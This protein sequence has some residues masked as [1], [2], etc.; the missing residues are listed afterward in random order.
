MALETIVPGIPVSVVANLT[1]E[2]AVLLP[3]PSDSRRQGGYE[4]LSA[5]LLEHEGHQ[6]RAWELSRRVLDA[7]PLDG[8]SGWIGLDLTLGDNREKIF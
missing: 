6:Q 2:E 5:E 1:K 7:L 3:M 8:S 4:Y